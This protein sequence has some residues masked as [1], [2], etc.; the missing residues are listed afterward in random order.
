[1][2]NVIFKIVLF[3]IKEP[4][5]WLGIYICCHYSQTVSRFEKNTSKS[6]TRAQIRGEHCSFLY[7]FRLI[8]I[9]ISTY[10]ESIDYKSYCID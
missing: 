8:C 7:L 4:C 5:M 9:I 3:Y 10:I 1:M 6:F 2:V